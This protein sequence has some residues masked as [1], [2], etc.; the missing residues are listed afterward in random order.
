MRCEIV[1]RAH[2]RLRNAARRAE[3]AARARAFTKNRIVVR[4]VEALEVDAFFLQQARELARR[5]HVIDILH[6]V[7]AELLAERLALLRR[8]RHDRDRDDI[9]RIEPFLFRIIRFDRRAHHGSWRFAGREV[10]HEVRIEQLAKAHPARAARC[11]MRQHVLLLRQA[12]ERLARLLHDRHVRRHAGVEDG[13]EA[14]R[15]ERRDLLA[16]DDRARRH[17]ELLAKRDLRRRCR[18]HNDELAVIV[19]RRLDLVHGR[20]LVNRARRAPH[21]A[22]AAADAGRLVLQRQR[23]VAVDADDIVAR[24]DA[25]AAENALLIVAHDGRILRRNR[26]AALQVRG[27]IAPALVLVRHPAVAALIFL[28]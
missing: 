6:V 18:L 24:L 19:E 7:M 22:L 1:E 3:D 16:A 12:H 8:A 23:I 25:L 13:I 26:D 20:T 5:Q 15:P 27:E 10:L 9:L 2:G 28:F 11:E 4:V 17:A 21:R 14:E